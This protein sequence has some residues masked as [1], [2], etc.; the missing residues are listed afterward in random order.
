MHNQTDLPYSKGYWIG[1]KQ[2]HTNLQNVESLKNHLAPEPELNHTDIHQEDMDFSTY[3]L[4]GLPKND[5]T[6][7][8][9]NPGM[10]GFSSSGIQLYIYSSAQKSKNL[11]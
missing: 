11:P 4:E 7:F 1:P 2:A 9:Q 8:S 5:K 3:N 10:G 6:C